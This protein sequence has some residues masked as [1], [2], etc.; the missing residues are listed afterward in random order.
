MDA[1]NQILQTSTRYTFDIIAINLIYALILGFFIA[2]VYTKTHRGVSYSQSF[3]HTLILLTLMTA[4]VMMIIGNNLARAFGLVGALSIVRFRTVVKDTKDTAYVFFSL[5]V[6]MAVGTNAYLVA[7]LGTL[8][9]IS[10]IVFLDMT[11]FGSRVKANFLLKFR[12][13][14][15]LFDDK[16]FQNLCRRYFLSSVLMNMSTLRMNELM[17]TIY[18]VQFK[19]SKESQ[20]FL[21]EI[22]DLAGLEKAQLVSM[23]EHQE[24]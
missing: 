2:F 6:G 17:E 3:V 9:G 19:D 11:N 18:E 20:Q 16:S 12:Y 1:L 7:L 23:I 21:T 4:V 13:H 15:N 14:P 22:R 5:V 8:A 10:V 24:F